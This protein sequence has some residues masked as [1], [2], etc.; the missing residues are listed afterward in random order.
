MWPQRNF[1]SIREL[2]LLV[3]AMTGKAPLHFNQVPDA[4]SHTVYG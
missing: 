4:K 1:A 2:Q 3:D